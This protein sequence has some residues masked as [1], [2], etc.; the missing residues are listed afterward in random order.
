MK[1]S[2]KKMNIRWLNIAWGQIITIAIAPLMALVLLS[3]CLRSQP[4]L[5]ASLSQVLDEY[6]Q[7][8]NQA[9]ENQQISGCILITKQGEIA[10]ANFYGMA[11]YQEQLPF[12]QDT[13]FLL[14][15]TTKLFTAIGIM[16]L[17]E[18][19]LLKVDDSI[20][21]YF[22]D[23]LWGEPITIR[24]LLT[25]TGGLLRDV[26]DQGLISPYEQTE[27]HRLQSLIQQS[28]LLFKP[29]SD[30]A[31]SNAG[32]QLLAGIIEKVTGL[33]Y[34][35]YLQKHIF[36]PANMRNTGCADAV[37]DVEKLAV[38][39]EYKYGNFRKK[40]PYNLS[41]AFG[42]GNIFTTPYDMA[43]F[44][45][46]LINGILIKAETFTQITTDNTGL[47]REY[48]YGCFVGTFDGYEWFGHP[49]NFSSGYFSYY[50][51]F[52]R[53]NVGLILLFNTVWYD[54]NS[55][56]KA[57]SAIVL[58][59][60]YSLPQKRQRISVAYVDP[61]CYEGIYQTPDGQA[62][63][64][65]NVDGLLLVSSDTVAYLAPCDENSFYDSY[66]EFWEYIFETNQNGKV[67]G[68][69]I[70]NGFDT[71]RLEKTEK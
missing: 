27:K 5:E 51:H 43:L 68:C 55:I 70:S 36:D 23:A 28:P 10:A 60:P 14:C 29:G 32:Y 46:A 50:V 3:V 45:K 18:K 4:P 61:A 24:Q 59:R 22:P 71:I 54:N 31:Y 67:I 25:H 63:T 30:M 65:K 66:N 8:L 41:H 15:S 53:E 35:E 20:A 1:R 58:Q 21:Q 56:M 39:Y 40:T 52:P 37:A 44:D 62:M 42:S 19:G 47:N 17:Q 16:Q 7:A 9:C 33:S 64:I 34:E 12:L 69:V 26:T 11:D 49:G 48:G 57:V 2:V 13:R 6:V 38:G